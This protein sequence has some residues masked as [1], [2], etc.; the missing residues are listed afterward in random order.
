VSPGWHTLWCSPPPLSSPG[1]GVC[2]EGRGEN[3]AN[4][5]RNLPVPLGTKALLK[6]DIRIPAAAAAAAV[7]E[8]SGLHPRTALTN[9]VANL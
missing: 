2:K 8:V 7:M 9:F 6:S 4:V 1:R 3:N 5:P